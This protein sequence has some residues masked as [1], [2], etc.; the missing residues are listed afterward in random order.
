[1]N[2]SRYNLSPSARRV[3]R[4]TSKAFLGAIV[5]GLSGAAANVLIASV[6]MLF[7]I[8]L[9]GNE[10]LPSLAPA[11]S[12]IAYEGTLVGSLTGLVVGLVA[13]WHG[14]QRRGA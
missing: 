13:A 2:D 4:Y 1:M 10:W 12:G 3:D 14:E 11:L 9:L 5:G 6:Q 7:L 8:K